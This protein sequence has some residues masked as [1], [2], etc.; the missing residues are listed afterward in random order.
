M[1]ST[2]VER[3]NEFREL[4]AAPLWLEL[5]W[6]EIKSSGVGVQNIKVKPGRCLD[7]Q[8]L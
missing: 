8:G 4:E 7:G 3:E 2:G 5:G 1:N 6:G